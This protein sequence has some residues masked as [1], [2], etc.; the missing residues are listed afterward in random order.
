[1]NQHRLVNDAVAFLFLHKQCYE[2]NGRS[3]GDRIEYARISRRSITLSVPGTEV[4]YL[5]PGKTYQ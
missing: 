4:R 1:M 3:K 5:M 2:A